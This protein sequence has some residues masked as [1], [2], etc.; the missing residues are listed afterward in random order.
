MANMPACCLDVRQID[1]KV[2]GALTHGGRCRDLVDGGCGMLHCC[3]GDGWGGNGWRGDFCDGDRLWRMRIFIFD[4]S[5][6]RLFCWLFY[7]IVGIASDLNFHK[8]R[9]NG[10]H[11]ARFARNLGDNTRNRAFHFNRRLVGHHIGKRLVFGDDIAN[12]H[13]P[14]DD[15]GLCNAFTNVRQ[16]ECKFGHRVSPS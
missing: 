10:D 15:F 9:A 5:Q 8:H 14:S 12:L 2:F 6:N 3:W 4:H 11:I 16:I 7:L 1:P 13:V